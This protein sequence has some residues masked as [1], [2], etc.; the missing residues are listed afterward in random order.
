MFL[1]HSNHHNNN[2]LPP[3]KTNGIESL[4]GNT[5]LIL[6]NS[7]S[8]YFN[9]EIYAK[10]ELNNLAGSAKDRVALSIIKK[11][12]KDGLIK[13]NNNDVIFEGT[14]GS[15][16]ISFATI[17]SPLGYKC[18]I[19]VP[20]D[21]SDEKLLLLKTLGAEIDK[22]SPAS[23]VD[24]NHNV[25][26]AKKLADQLTNDKSTNSVGFFA[27]QFENEQ[28]W[29][30]HFD[31]T[32]PEIYSQLNAQIDYFVHGCGTGGTI[33]GVSK[34]LKSKSS[35]V[36]TYLADP[37]GSG[38]FNR[39]NHGVMYN[40]VERE[41][42]RRRHQID[43]IIEGIGLN[44]IT[45]NFLAGED[46][47]D[48]A[49]RVTDD[50]ALKMAKFLLV[51]D[52]LFWGSSSAVSCVAAIKLAQKQSQKGKKIVVIACDSGNRH[53]S[54]FWK[55]ASKISSDISIEEILK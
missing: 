52:G 18:H 16:G 22:V 41:G 40:N 54:K 6:I 19:S 12:E 15:T 24:P 53:L 25:N 34:Y 47:I 31:T 26:I 13:P 8:N 43:T 38:F 2:H 44:R 35:T 10:L 48:G 20:S 36:K 14:S 27:N 37:Q 21:T 51:N 1:F 33:T 55:E 11:A 4:I 30:T 7:L 28:N 32:G 42:H 46:L 50:Q 5:P 49:I 9:C 23:I 39:I 3:V 17:A 29:K 45:K